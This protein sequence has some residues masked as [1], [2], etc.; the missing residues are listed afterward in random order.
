MLEGECTYKK[1]H[2]T[3]AYVYTGKG[4]LTPFR[5]VARWD[6]NGDGSEL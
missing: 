2:V 6:N 1:D 3:D 5:D 4:T